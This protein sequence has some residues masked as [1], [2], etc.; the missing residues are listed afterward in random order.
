MPQI[1]KLTRAALIIALK[2][3]IVPGIILLLLASFGV[4]GAVLPLIAVPFGMVFVS[5]ALAFPVATLLLPQQQRSS[6]PAFATAL[7]ML[8]VVLS[9][10]LS[11]AGQLW[12][13]AGGRYQFNLGG[14]LRLG[15]F[16][17]VCGCVFFL[18]FTK[19]WGRL[20]N[21]NA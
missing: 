8:I 4:Q 2:A 10:S 11:V 13:I 17:S 7:A 9:F 14:V 5:A 15:L 18:P 6:T 19:A 1:R 21:G 20:M 3:S 12:F 16:L